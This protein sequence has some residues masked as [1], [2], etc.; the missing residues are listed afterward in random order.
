MINYSSYNDVWGITPNINKN[1]S[2]KV[3]ET[4]DSNTEN[5]KSE[6][7]KSENFKSNLQCENSICK[8]IDHILNCEKCLKKLKKKLL[9]RE[10]Y[11]K[12]KENFLIKDKIFNFNS[13][14]KNFL[15]M[16]CNNSDTKK[17]ILLILFISLF[18]ILS[19]YFVQ[20]RGLES[21]STDIEALAEAVSAVDLNMK[22]LKEN[23][24]MIPKNMINFN[25]FIA[26]N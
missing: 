26:P 4:F 9:I 23:F 1:T 12:T 8:N 19:F 13:N 21:T 14:I 5:L 2:N 17:K 25:N 16:L 24:V 11:Q 3:N 7:A 22:Y 10:P 15:L 20:G 18:L 6:N